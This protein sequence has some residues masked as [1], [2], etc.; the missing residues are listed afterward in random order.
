MISEIPPCYCIPQVEAV[1]VEIESVDHA[2]SLLGPDDYARG[3]RST[4]FV[5]SARS[6]GPIALAAEPVGSCLRVVV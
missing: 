2:L 1:K 6:D 3:G 4:D 5:F